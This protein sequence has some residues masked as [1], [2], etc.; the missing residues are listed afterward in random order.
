MKKSTYCLEADA[1]DSK[2]GRDGRKPSRNRKCGRGTGGWRI[3]HGRAS[4]Q[5]PEGS[6]HFLE[7]D[8]TWEKAHPVDRENSNPLFAG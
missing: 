1:D 2:D 6:T 8:L 7:V 4:M 3:V 5:P